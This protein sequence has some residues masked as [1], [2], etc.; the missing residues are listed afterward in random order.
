MRLKL[1]HCQVLTREISHVLSRSPHSI[2]PE[3]LTMGLH[4]LGA[5]MRPYLQE[6]ID[7]ADEGGI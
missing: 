3:M 5:S 1:I 4:D 2:D 7:A 6:R